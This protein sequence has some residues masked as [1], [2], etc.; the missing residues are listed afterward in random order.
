MLYSNFFPNSF[1]IDRKGVG[2]NKTK[3]HFIDDDDV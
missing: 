3:K 2:S 1:H